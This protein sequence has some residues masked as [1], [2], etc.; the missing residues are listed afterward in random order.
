MADE[1]SIFRWMSK[2]HRE[3]NDRKIRDV[4]IGVLKG[5]AA[6]GDLSR[7]HL[8]VLDTY[9]DDNPELRARSEIL[10]IANYANFV[11]L[12]DGVDDDDR[13]RMVRKIDRFVG[14]KAEHAGDKAIDEF[15][16]MCFGLNAMRNFGERGFAAIKLWCSSNPNAAGLWPVS[17]FPIHLEFR[18]VNIDLAALVAKV[19]SNP[20]G[21]GVD[22]SSAFVALEKP[23]QVIDFY[24]GPICFHGASVCFTGKFLTGIRTLCSELTEAAGAQV[25]RSVHSK[26]TYLVVGTVGSEHW[27]YSNFG[28]KI[29]RFRE[30]DGYGTKSHILREEDWFNAL[31]DCTR[32]RQAME[33]MK[34]GNARW[35]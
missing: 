23:T 17:E 16:G 27:Y 30:F 29:E 6:G 35:M 19:C 24:R 13:I 26:L 10:K 3:N 8:E 31:P 20:E 1:D 25:D 11:L 18:Q 2:I 22:V 21:A 4:T 33:T 7:D 5:L 9:V 12:K 14:T 32:K 28:R 34:S 15:I